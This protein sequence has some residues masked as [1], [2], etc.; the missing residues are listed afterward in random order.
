MR[1]RGCWVRGLAGL[2]AV[3]CAV[4]GFVARGA[5]RSVAATTATASGADVRLATKL[6]AVLGSLNASG[7]VYGARVVELS[8]GRELYAH[9]PDRPLMPASNG[10]LANDAAGLDHFG[11]NHTFKTYLAIDGED[12]WLIGTGDPGCGD[13]VI[14]AAHHSKP[15]AMLEE[16]AQA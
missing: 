15:T 1:N 4:L 7:A 3:L 11:P 6:N 8:T 5:E 16:W 14:A 10:K 2:A 12:L 13:E 9:E